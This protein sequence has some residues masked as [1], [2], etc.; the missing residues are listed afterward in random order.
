MFL[1]SPVT[2]EILFSGISLKK[3]QARAIFSACTSGCECWLNEL[4]VQ[5]PSTLFRHPIVV[6]ERK[7]NTSEWNRRLGVKPLNKKRNSIRIAPMKAINLPPGIL[8]KKVQCIREWIIRTL[9]KAKLSP[10]YGNVNVLSSL[11]KL[12]KANMFEVL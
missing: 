11:E 10:T 5:N 1:S 8:A 6:T 3:R 9:Q 12:M 2:P 7:E 4:D